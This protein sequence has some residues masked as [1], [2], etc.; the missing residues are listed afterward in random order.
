MSVQFFTPRGPGQ[1]V[2]KLPSAL[3]R[4]V[5][6]L[7]QIGDLFPDFSVETTHGLMRFWD[8][9]DGHWVHL[10]SHPAAFT[11][12][13]TTE[14]AS[15]A[16]H[17]DSW[18]KHGIKNLALT[19]STVQ[20]QREWHADIE[21]LFDLPI[22]FPGAYDP[23][24]RLSAL[25]GMIH[26]KE[27]STWPIRKSFLIDPAQRVRMIFEYPVFVGRNTDEVL[28]VARALQLHD[29]TGAAT[30]ADWYDGD[31]AIIPDQRTEASVQRDFGET[32]TRLRSYLR[33]VGVAKT[34]TWGGSFQPPS[35]G[36][37]LE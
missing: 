35:S 15:I 14:I 33:V 27:S 18:D 10:F 9:A 1:E 21:D 6:W 34:E 30:P 8:W 4:R 5:K 25:F 11:P 22:D 12:V 20:E 23:G 24:L 19:G 7:P 2:I 3:R 31:M 16:S 13:C 28:R 26:E 32:S 29:R 37:S 17:A 36:R